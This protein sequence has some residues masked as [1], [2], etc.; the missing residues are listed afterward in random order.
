MIK[1]PTTL[2]KKSGYG[3]ASVQKRLGEIVYI[4]SQPELMVS[5]QGKHMEAFRDQVQMLGMVDNIV[6]SEDGKNTQLVAK[7]F[8]IDKDKKKDDLDNE[9]D[10]DSDEGNLVE[11]M[12]EANEMMLKDKKKNRK[13]TKD[14]D[15][16]VGEK[17]YEHDLEFLNKLKPEEVIKLDS[18]FKNRGRSWVKRDMD[19][20]QKGMW[21]PSVG[22][23][24]P[25][26]NAARSNIGDKKLSIQPK[27]SEKASMLIKD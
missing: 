4:S 16:N 7:T 24:R 8:N 26:F 22:T 25:N 21:H 19:E 15:E 14:V 20:E 10:I 13:K 27:P 12:M 18:A 6:K 9:S 2:T 23:Y 11:K 17:R 1:I 3:A 5:R